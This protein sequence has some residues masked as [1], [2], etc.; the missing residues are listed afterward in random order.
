MNSF[1]AVH[2]DL[3]FPVAKVETFSEAAFCPS[4]LCLCVCWSVGLV[5]L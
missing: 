1:Q 3:F 4:A 5:T 2:N